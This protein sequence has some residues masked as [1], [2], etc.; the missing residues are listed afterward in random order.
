MEFGNVNPTQHLMTK[1]NLEKNPNKSV[2]TGISTR[3]SSIE[4][5]PRISI[6]AMLCAFTTLS[7]TA[8]HRRRRSSRIQTRPGSMDFFR[9]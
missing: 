5:E 9:A 8:L 4:Y 1:G 7:H 3:N 6:G 2:S